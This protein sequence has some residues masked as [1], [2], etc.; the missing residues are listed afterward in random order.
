MTDTSVPWNNADATVEMGEPN[1]GP[2]TDGDGCN[3]QDGWCNITD[4]N[5]P[6]VQSSVWHKFTA[7]SNCV[8]ISIR[9]SRLDMQLALWGVTTGGS[10]CPGPAFSNLTEIAANDNS[11]PGVIS[12]I[13]LNATVTKGQVYYSQ[14][15]GFNR[16]MGSDIISYSDCLVRTEEY[17]Y[18]AQ[19]GAVMCLLLKS[20][21]RHQILSFR[22]PTPLPH[23]LPPTTIYAALR[24]S[25]LALR[26]LGTTSTPRMRWVSPIRGRGQGQMMT[27]VTRRTVGVI[28]LIVMS[29]VSKVRFGTSSKQQATV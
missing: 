28:S 25:L 26:S 6:G 10:V 4:S 22:Y 21:S 29:L 20:F 14:L 1:P 23:S 9:N 16:G 15:D 27:V 18:F 7:T 13:I 12:P 8:T 19:P 2:G 17:Q 11:E 24:K 5:E 3:S